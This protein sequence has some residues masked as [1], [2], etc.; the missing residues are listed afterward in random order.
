MFAIIFGGA[1]ALYIL[2]CG[3]LFFAQRGMLFAGV[4]A[5]APPPPTVTPAG[6]ERIWLETASGKVEAWF[7][8]ATRARQGEHLPLIIFAHGNAE[9]IDDWPGQFKDFADAGL[10][11][12]LVE[13]PGFG[14]SEGSPSQKTVTDVFITAYDYVVTRAD[15]D[16]S[17]IVLLGRS[18][19]GGAICT[20]AANRPSAALILQSTFT[21]V[22]PFAAK[23]RAPAFLV[24]DPFDSLAVV[25]A[26]EQP[27]LIFH[28]SHDSVIPYEHGVALYKAAKHG[29]MITY[30]SDH[31][32]C[33]PDWKGFVR[34][35]TSFLKECGILG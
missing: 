19:G 11:S 5:P 34:D 7:I 27:V 20:L 30:D 32:D 10:G 35:A 4:H 13:Y 25:G 22:R 26:Y 14:R 23:H 15:V 31:N 28:G 24:R 12:L 29:K 17:R 8:P 3:M 33:P 16:S 1:I 6:M 18:L 2:Y 21:S 9:L